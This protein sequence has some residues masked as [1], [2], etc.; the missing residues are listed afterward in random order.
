MRELRSHCRLGSCW[1]TASYE[2]WA[3]FQLDGDCWPAD[4]FA[5][6]IHQRYEC[7]EL[8]GT[9]S[10]SF[11]EPKQLSR[12]QS[13]STGRFTLLNNA[14]TRGNAYQYERFATAATP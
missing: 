7:R 2:I 1:H 10:L 3:K 11:S 12:I 14:F 5:F 8:H 13:S 9:R 4:G 6:C